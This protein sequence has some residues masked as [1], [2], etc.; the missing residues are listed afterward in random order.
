MAS[1]KKHLIQVRSN[2]TM[3]VNYEN[4]LLT[5]QVEIILLTQEPVYKIKK[6]KTESFIEKDRELSEYRCFAT[7][8]A[9]NEMISDL[10]KVASEL[11]IFAQMSGSLNKVIEQYKKPTDNTQPGSV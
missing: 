9:I 5:P 8:D 2:C 11:Q 10:Q 1:T 6:V 3:S 7:L 4:L